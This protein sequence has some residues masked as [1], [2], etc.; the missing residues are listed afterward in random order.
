[1]VIESVP[2]AAKL[3]FM[4][5]PHF[6]HDLFLQ[7]CLWTWEWKETVWVSFLTCLYF[8]RV[9]YAEVSHYNIK[10]DSG[11][12]SIETGILYTFGNLMVFYS[13]VIELFV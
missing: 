6:A 13:S 5:V 12:T 9:W 7:T 4:L 2:L 1:M 3:F 11:T 8:M 10:N